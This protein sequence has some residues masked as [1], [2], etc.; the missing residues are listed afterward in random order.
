MKLRTLLVLTALAISAHAEEKDF[1]R[2]GPVI[3]PKQLRQGQ[4]NM[5]AKIGDQNPGITA[6]ERPIGRCSVPLKNLTPIAP[7]PKMPTIA[8][9]DNF[10]YTVKYAAPPAPPC[11]PYERQ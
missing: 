10:K 2:Q 8:P 9:D 3:T 4:W 11:E 5:Q 1:L 6:A 7:A